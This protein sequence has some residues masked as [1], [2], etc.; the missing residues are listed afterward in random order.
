MFLPIVPSKTIL[1]HTIWY[2]PLLQERLLL[3]GVDIQSS[4]D[5]PCDMTMEG[6][7]ARVVCLILQNN[8]SRGGS[9]TTLH[10]LYITPLSVLLMDD[11]A[12]P[13][14]NALG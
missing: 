6:P 11:L 10:E 7:Y 2:D 8:I 9:R 5:M 3:D 4:A 13:G 12:V 1:S 14:S